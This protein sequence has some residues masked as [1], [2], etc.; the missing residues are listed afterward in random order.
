MRKFNFRTVEGLE[1]ENIVDYIKNKM[2]DASDVPGFKLLI[3][4]DSLPSKKSTAVYVTSVC[5]YYNGKGGHVIY[6]RDINV[7]VY[8]TGKNEMLKNRLWEEI[9]RVVDL[10]A[11]IMDS[12]L[13]SDKRIEKFEVHVDINPNEKF[14]SNVIYKDVVGYMESMGLDAYAKP[15]SPAA[16]YISDSICRGKEEKMSGEH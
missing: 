8:G 5:L 12:D 10:A 7:K 16:T 11:I 1:I 3:G 15:D 14:G 13:L 9:F 6:S 2:D 4:C